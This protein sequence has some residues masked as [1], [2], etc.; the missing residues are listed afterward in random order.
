MSK[1]FYA[2]CLKLYKSKSF[3]FCCLGAI[4]MSIMVVMMMKA[5]EEMNAM[6]MLPDTMN[7]L[8]EE[9]L[10]DNNGLTTLKEIFTSN[11]I[12]ILTAIFASIFV[13]IEYT[14]GAIKN[15]ASKGFSRIRI[16]FMKYGIVLFATEVL[17]ILVVVVTSILIGVIWGFDSISQNISSYMQFIG[18][19]LLIQLAITGVYIMI[20][21][22]SRNIGIGIAINICLMGFV[23][24]ILQGIDLITNH[25][26]NISEYWVMQMVS[27]VASLELEQ[28][29]IIKCLIMIVIYLILTFAIGAFYFEK[30]D[31]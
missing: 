23:S 17:S 2:E 19:N 5:M 10:Q 16:Y 22:I 13:C 20:A 9:L 4:I 12:Q 29:V 18:I 25:K 27:D 14:N 6:N 1:L 24:L 30:K 15:I 3:V 31:I 21:T 7:S 8:T 26:I 28:S 11:T